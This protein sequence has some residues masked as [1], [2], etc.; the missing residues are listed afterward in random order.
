M[1]R[2]AARTTHSNGTLQAVGLGAHAAPPR[3]LMS[4]RERRAGLARFGETILA[5]MGLLDYQTAGPSGRGGYP[6]AAGTRLLRTFA[7][8]SLS[9]DAVLE[10][11]RAILVE[12]SRGLD[13]ATIGYRPFIR[14]IT[15]FVIG[16]GLWPRA[17]AGS[18]ADRA[19]TYFRAWGNDPTRCDARGASSWP[20]MQRSI[21]RESLLAGD[22]LALKVASDGLPAGAVQVVEAERIVS[23]VLVKR[24]AR[25]GGESPTITEGVEVGDAGRAVAFHVGSWDAF[26]SVVGP[27]PRRVD[28]SACC[29]FAQR[30][31][32][33]TARGVPVL[34]NGLE[35]LAMLD[36]NQ[37]A[38][39]AAV[40][41]AACMAG[42]VKSKSPAQTSTVLKSGTAQTPG[43]GD[44]PTETARDLL[45]VGPGGLLFLEP[46]EDFSMV[47][48]AQ[49]TAGYGAYERSVLRLVAASAG[50]PIEIVLGDLSE[51]NFSV[52][53]MAQIL[54]SR[55]AG[56]Q[57]DDFIAA[58]CRP[59]YRF[60]IARAV[61]TG[62]LPAPG[63]QGGP[64][65]FEEYL[66]VTWPD[67]PVPMFQ[68][69]V[70]QRA[71]IEAIAHNLESKQD[72]II[73]RGGDPDQVFADRAAEVEREAEL[74]I[75]PPPLAGSS[76]AQANSTAEPAEDGSHPEDPGDGVR[77]EADPSADPSDTSAAV[78]S[79]PSKDYNGSQIES[80]K[81]IITGVTAGEIAPDAAVTM[82]VEFLGLNAATARAIVNAQLAQRE[83]A[84]KERAAEQ[85]KEPAPAGPSE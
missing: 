8:R 22:V 43:T 12:F 38:I 79:K 82:L 78:P 59:I 50:Y 23:P 42:I 6:A 45:G 34:A 70:E 56:P 40:R 68:P 47:Q 4:A 71:K 11:D 53:R 30:D 83:A 65:S 7:G 19:V 62:G 52:A 14:N 58:V 5:S 29:F 18:P 72:V 37:V 10:R 15:S 3:A 74:G 61:L 63:A 64:A 2:G 76:P 16:R 35:R 25:E 36:G 1:K 75:T 60:I 32:E 51:A 85:A 27:D 67:P 57:R 48:G 26:G 49:P 46:D 24:V 54:A 39:D 80:A 33:G 84:K 41:L 28:S 31:R 55:T 69:E 73:E 77:A 66:A 21:Y 81:G 44:S 13:A 9:G 17:R 20:A